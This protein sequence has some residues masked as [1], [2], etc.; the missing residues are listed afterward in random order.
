VLILTHDPWDIAPFV[1]QH[2]YTMA[3][4]YDQGG[5]ELYN[6]GAIPH[7]YF[8]DSAGNM[9]DDYAGAMTADQLNLLVKQIL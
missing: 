7:T 5:Y 9:V 1:A 3:F 2:K 6:V 8:I 4:G